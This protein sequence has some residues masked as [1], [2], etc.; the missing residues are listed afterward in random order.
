MDVSQRRAASQVGTGIRERVR[1]WAPPSLIE[2]L[3]WL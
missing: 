3:P 1:D 2:H